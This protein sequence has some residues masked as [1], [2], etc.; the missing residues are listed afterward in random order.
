M[1]CHTIINQQ[2][3]EPCSYANMKFNRGPP[4]HLLL[5][6]FFGSLNLPILGGRFCTQRLAALIIAW[7]LTRKD[8]P[9]GCWKN[10][11]T[12]TLKIIQSANGP[13]KLDHSIPDH[14]TKSSHPELIT[15]R[16]RRGMAWMVSSSP[17]ISTTSSTALCAFPWA[18][19]CACRK[20]ERNSRKPGLSQFS[21]WN[22]CLFLCP[23]SNK[24][25]ES[26]LLKDCF[27]VRGTD[28]WVF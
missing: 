1:G 7:W 18:D 14:S 23:Q 15:P 19:W 28:S 16:A 21:P 11:S 13:Q 26:R 25:P 10:T 8:W 24:T 5:A 6:C 9:L 22:I 3:F 2:G 17:G 27:K 12:E 4:S 20:Q